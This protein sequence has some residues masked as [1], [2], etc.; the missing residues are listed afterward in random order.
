MS[1]DEKPKKARRYPST[2]PDGELDATIKEWRLSG[3]DV[4][5]RGNI[6][7]CG[8]HDGVFYQQ[9]GDDWVLVNMLG[10]KEIL[11]EIM[12]EQTIKSTSASLRT[13]GQNQRIVGQFMANLSE[14]RDIAG[15]KKKP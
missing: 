7:G 5:D 2:I 12:K 13:L 15:E 10:I 4:R 9:V 1:E 8:G 3:L 14:H 11:S 6:V